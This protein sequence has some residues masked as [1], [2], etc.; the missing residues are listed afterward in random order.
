[1]AKGLIRRNTGYKGMAKIGRASSIS[2]RPSFNPH[3]GISL[4]SYSEEAVEPELTSKNAKMNNPFI[5]D[6]YFLDN[7]DKVLG[8]QTKEKGQWGNDII[9]V[10]GDFSS[11]QK[12]DAVPVAVADAYP[13]EVY[14]DET[15]QSII[16]DVFKEEN[17][18]ENKKRIKAIRTGGKGKPKAA[19]S[20]AS[21]SVQEVYSFR[22]VGEMYNDNI[23]KDELDAY[24]FSH[25]ELN[26]KLLFDEYSNDKNSLIQKGLLCY[27]DGKFV[28]YYTYISGNVNKKIS[29]LQKDKEKVINAVGQVQ[30][31][32]QLKM[33]QDVRPKSKGFVG[34][35]KI[36]LLPHSNFAKE[37]QITELRS[38]KPELNGDTS[39]FYAFKRWIR[40]QPPDVFTKSN[41]FEV[42]EFYLDNK[43]IEINKDLKGKEKEKAEKNAINI[44][45]R[46]KEEGDALFAVFLAEELLPEDQA[47]V[48]YLWNE[49]YNSIVEPDLSKIPV[50]FQ[51]AKTWKNGAPFKL[52]NTQRQAVA[53]QMEKKSGLLAYGVGVGKTTSAV[54]CFSQAYYNGIAKKGIVVAPTNTY[55]NWLG[56]IQGYVDKES[57]V[58]MQGTMPQ[59]PPV[60][61]LFNLNPQ[62]VRDTLKIYTEKEEAVLASIL[63]AAEL[64]KTYKDELSGSRKMEISKIYD[65]NWNGLM[66]E[67]EFSLENSSAKRV[68]SFGDFVL[69]YL[70]MEYNYK[71]YELGSIKSFPDGTIFVTTEVGL[72]RLGITDANK[73]E[74]VS[75]MFKILSQGEVAAGSDRAKE[76]AAL[77]LKIEQTVSS[78]MKYAKVNIE[79][80]G[81]DWACFDEAHYYKK[82]FTFVKGTITGTR[83][84]SE[85]NTKYK[86]E[87][88]KYEIKSGSVPS[89]RA[90][91]AFKLSHFI[92]SKND[93]RN[94]LMLTA[95]PFTNSPLEVFSML[96]LTNYKELEDMGLDNMVDFF[97]TFMKINYD[98]KYTPQKTVVK[99]IVLTGYNNLSQMRQIIYSLMDKKDAGA[100]LIRPDKHIFPSLEKGI[101]TTLPMTQEQ[102]ELM[103]HVKEY[104]NGNAEYDAICR[105]ALVDEI[106]NT[107]FDA[108]DDEA[109]I[110][111]WERNTMKEYTGDSENLSESTRENLIRQMRNTHDDGMEMDEEDL[112]EAE[113]LGVRILRGLSMMRQITLSPFLYYKACRKASGEAPVLPDADEYIKS[114]PKLQYVVGCIKSVIDYHRERDE[115]I[116]GQ[117]IYMNAGVEY[118]PLIK[119][120]VAKAC[121][122]KESQ[123]GIVSGQM[124]KNAKETVKRQFLNGEIVVLIGSSTI[125]VGVNLQENASCLYNCYYDW[126]PTD[127][128][129]IEGRI[130]R[131][132]N[133]F[134]NVRIVYPQCY[135][136]ADPVIFEYLNSKTLRINEIWNRSSELQE[137][138]LRDFNPKELQKKLITDPEEKAEWEILQ[139][140]DE[141][142]SKIIYFEN[143]REMLNSAMSSYR[144]YKKARPEV[145]NILNQISAKKS[146]LTKKEAVKAQKDKMSEIVEKYSEDPDKMAKEINNYKKTRYDH[147]LDPEEKYVSIDYNTVDDERIYAA[148][149]KYIDVLSDMDYRD[150][151]EW[152]DIYRN[153][154]SL[155]RK[156]EAFRYDFKD[157][158]ASEY[159]V[160][161]PMGL[162]FE[163]AQNPI[164]EFDKN[165][166]ELTEQL[167]GIE[168]SKP[169][170]VARIKAELDLQVNTIK[171]VSERVMEFASYNHE[172]LS[173]FL[174]APIAEQPHQLV[175]IAEELLEDN[176]VAETLAAMNAI[177]TEDMIPVAKEEQVEY[178]PAVANEEE[179]ETPDE[180]LRRFAGATSFTKF[181]NAVMMYIN[182]GIPESFLKSELGI[183][184][185]DVQGNLKKLRAY[186]DA[187]SGQRAAV[188]Q[189]K[190]KDQEEYS[191]FMKEYSDAKTMKTVDTIME[192]AFNASAE[193][194]KKVAEY[195]A[196]HPNVPVVKEPEPIKFPS[197]EAVEEVMES[198]KE[199]IMN[200]IKDLQLAAK[201]ADAEEK[202]NIKEAI[203]ALKLSLQYL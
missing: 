61:G 131:Q 63:Q 111:E 72:Q 121:N 110:A 42:N 149:L 5:G 147:D 17:D 26:H 132:G 7:P 171:S 67:Y 172:M 12:I 66:G 55:P 47:K 154:G 40:V 202:K 178:V 185:G 115:K 120:A 9:K 190:R 141:I 14:T 32:R 1:M 21:T 135:N 90:L 151:Q 48:S 105:S 192:M 30:Y 182:D 166:E 196:T 174:I 94:V 79:D 69:T 82:L 56:E 65:L 20:D 187:Q 16:Q 180:M 62:I 50:C 179:I 81:I 25:P 124:S 118:F 89:S 27:E 31:E 28:Y 176:T 134:A 77:Q 106:E 138:D 189:E 195:V 4:S 184:S 168:D 2:E 201:Y 39:L 74:L 33:L 73:E 194:D 24:Y 37:T 36:T 3:Q 136:S 123:I 92:Q 46:T 155:Q 165:L 162:S 41:Y 13:T 156:L 99:D 150:D 64:L 101:E 140:T 22:E 70:Y 38:G 125:S 158:R 152:G 84:D 122:L 54:V 127:A 159:K 186:Y 49:K 126:N 58:F 107:D 93:N 78:S 97:D 200:E 113:S 43:A 57:G 191:T 188:R 198:T 167:K 163:T 6:K 98:I 175:P 157:M 44:R 143:R 139:S 108:L 10:S 173:K 86:R 18:A 23:S 199:D 144:S 96:T 119:K 103:M 35:D 116:S 8:V 177:P 137:L 34:D 100:N 109:L 85:G 148:C 71:V 181:K 183:V 146:E 29:S 91:S 95:T 11:I 45:Q 59:L 128:A 83:E 68:K 75:K 129:Q 133:R 203:S 145:I 60:V 169:E 80:I 88:S 197:D 102:N 104:I 142:Q 87:K 193:M 117:V 19:K 51:I 164:A 160:L 153:H 130:W 161:K 52:N 112:D 170:R 114:S 15:K 53:F 76:V